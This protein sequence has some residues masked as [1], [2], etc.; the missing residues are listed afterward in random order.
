MISC[1]QDSMA[2]LTAMPGLMRTMSDL[3][4]ALAVIYVI[5]YL[6]SRKSSQDVSI[7]TQAVWVMVFMTRYIDFIEGRFISVYNTVGKIFFLSTSIFIGYLARKY[8]Q[9]GAQKLENYSLFRLAVPSLLLA[10]L[11]NYSAPLFLWAFDTSYPW[12]QH[13]WSMGSGFV[14]EFLWTFSKHLESFAILPQLA[15]V[16][17]NAP[18]I[19]TTFTFTYVGLL[20]LYKT[21]YLAKAG[22]DLAL[23]GFWDPIGVDT[24]ALQLFIYLLAMWS[25]SRIKKQTQPIYLGE[26]QSSMEKGIMNEKVVEVVLVDVQNQ[27][28]V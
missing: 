27:N 7:Q 13:A 12:I 2:I 9:P 10:L 17:Q 16:R 4:H 22:F 15:L 1:F 21:F 18:M 19:D 23:N 3:T 5:Y 25:V 20:A 24:A 28:E 26:D 14:E 8:Q 11:F 6:R